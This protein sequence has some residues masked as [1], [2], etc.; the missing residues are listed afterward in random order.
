MNAII[1]PLDRESAEKI[2]RGQTSMLPWIKNFKRPV[3]RIVVAI[4]APIGQLAIGAV[5]VESKAWVNKYTASNRILKAD[6]SLPK[7]YWYDYENSHKVCLFKLTKEVCVFDSPV[8]VEDL[9]GIRNI[10]SGMYLEEG[11][12]D[13]LIRII[14]GGFD[15]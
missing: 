4:K 7:M 9:A 2:L 3:D 1:L 10:G 13:N 6:A 8:L 5:G 11:I 12:D 14:G 15:E